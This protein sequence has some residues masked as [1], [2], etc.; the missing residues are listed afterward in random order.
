MF[1]ETYDR[2]PFLATMS[3]EPE[4]LKQRAES[5]EALCAELRKAGK[6]STNRAFPMA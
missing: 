3:T 2:I 6:R 5:A 1:K 4:Q